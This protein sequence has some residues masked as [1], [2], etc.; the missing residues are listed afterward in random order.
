MSPSSSRW[1]GIQKSQPALA[2][3][4]PATLCVAGPR[5]DTEASPGVVSRLL[6]KGR[7][8]LAWARQFRSRVSALD[9]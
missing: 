2:G 1:M 9:K 6:R 7:S 5:R 3:P 8:P 4:A